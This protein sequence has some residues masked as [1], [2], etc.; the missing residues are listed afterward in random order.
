MQRW[1]ER[2]KQPRDTMISTSTS[3]EGPGESDSWYKLNLNWKK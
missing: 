3:Y 2:E 1:K